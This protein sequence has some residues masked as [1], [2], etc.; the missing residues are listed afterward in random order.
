MKNTMLRSIE[1]LIN[2]T[3]DTKWCFGTKNID[4]EFRQFVF[5]AIKKFHQGSRLMF[6][7]FLKF[8]LKEM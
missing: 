7:H 8:H 5:I 6:L 1:N 3:P 2:H 4:S